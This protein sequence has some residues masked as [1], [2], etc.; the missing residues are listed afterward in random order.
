[1]S[2]DA[3]NKP[4]IWLYFRNQGKELEIVNLGRMR[5]DITLTQ[6]Q[7]KIRAKESEMKREAGKM[8]KVFE[9]SKL[10]GEQNAESQHDWEKA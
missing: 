3:K 1:M 2:N 5:G 8:R 9:K 7:K 6:K 4:L 10:S